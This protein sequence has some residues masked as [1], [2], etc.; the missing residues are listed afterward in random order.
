[1]T[2]RLTLHPYTRA[3]HPAPNTLKRHLQLSCDQRRPQPAPRTCDSTG[4]RP[5][6][7]VG[8]SDPANGVAGAQ[9]RSQGWS[10]TCEWARE[11]PLG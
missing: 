8:A 2:L 6:G 9:G 3:A 11:R 7:Q 10:Q 1:M 4:D 5:S